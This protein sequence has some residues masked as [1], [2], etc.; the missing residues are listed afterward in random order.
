MI[1][2]KTQ[3]AERIPIVDKMNRGVFL[4]HSGCPGDA[5]RDGGRAVTQGENGTG[6]QSEWSLAIDRAGFAVDV[7]RVGPSDDEVAL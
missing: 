2:G 3:D 1:D 7:D 6:G 5:D 4:L